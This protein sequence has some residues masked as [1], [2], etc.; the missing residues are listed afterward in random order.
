MGQ[1]QSHNKLQQH[2]GYFNPE[3]E[4]IRIVDDPIYGR[5]KHVKEKNSK[6]TYI[7]KELAF[8]ANKFFE[9]EL[10][11][12]KARISFD[13]P[14]IVRMLGYNV[15]ESQQLCS[16]MYKIFIFI[17]RLDNDLDSQLR[18]KIV[19]EDPYTENELLFIAENLTSLLYNLQMRNTTHGDIRPSSI[20]YSEKEQVFKLTDPQLE[21][22]R[23]SNG[24][25]KAVI[26]RA[27]AF[28]APEI[29]ENVPKRKVEHH[30]DKYKTDVFSL[31][32]TLLGLATLTH[33]EE[34]F[35]Y[36]NGALNEHLLRDR[37]EKVQ[38]MYSTFTYELI[39]EM[40][41]YDDYNRPNFIDIEDKLLPYHEVIRRKRPLPFKKESGLPHPHSIEE[42]PVVHE[43][44]YEHEHEHIERNA[45]T[46]KA[47]AIQAKPLDSIAILSEDCEVEEERGFS[48]H[49][50]PDHKSDGVFMSSSDLQDEDYPEEQDQEKYQ[51]EIIKSKSSV[52]QWRSKNEFEPDDDLDI[53]IKRALQ[54]TQETYK[55]VQEVDSLPVYV[56]HHDAEEHHM[57]RDHE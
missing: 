50:M 38:A 34:L 51:E 46:S 10:E 39:L 18:E 19:N 5:I 16:K 31:G 13:H 36:K 15:L 22:D 7:L 48:S 14:N 11:V 4:V 54:R 24:L 2:R 8:N 17:E 53:Q 20:F 6:N 35:D 23:N 9:E 45:A 44:E 33:S 55:Q 56:E 52:E 41:A 47:S 40:L 49:K 26:H 27:E 30:A 28:L 21:V 37:L 3:Y 1:S 25:T 12:L 29:L 57:E 32:A 42:M 43:H